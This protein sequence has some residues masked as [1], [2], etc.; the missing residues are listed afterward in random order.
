[1]EKPYTLE[2]SEST[3]D[4]LYNVS[5]PVVQSIPQLGHT[6]VHKVMTQRQSTR[7]R[8]TVYILMLFLMHEG[9]PQ[10]LRL[11]SSI[12]RFTNAPDEIPLYNICRIHNPLMMA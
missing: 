10:Q 6:E 1:L 4:F 12:D 7:A 5:P 11:I 8:I 2:V 3:G 9:H